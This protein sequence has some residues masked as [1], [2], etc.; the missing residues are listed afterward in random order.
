MWHRGT[1]FND[2]RPRA[3]PLWA[4]CLGS[5]F[6]EGLRDSCRDATLGFRGLPEAQKAFQLFCCSCYRAIVLSC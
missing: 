1:G 5:V 6:T 3:A 4:G 2:M